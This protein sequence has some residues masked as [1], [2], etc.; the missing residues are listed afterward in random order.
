[1]KNIGFDYQKE[2]LEQDGTEHQLGGIGR[3]IKGIADEIGGIVTG[4]HAWSN[5]VD[6]I[7]QRILAQPNHAIDI[8]KEESKPYLPIGTIQRGREDW[9]NCTSNSCNNEIEIQHNYAIEKG[10]F[11]K[12][13]IQWF[14]ENK[15]IINGKFEI[16]DGFVSIGSGTTKT[17]NSLK[18]PLSFIENTGLIPKAMMPD[19]QSMTFEEYHRLNRVTQEMNDMAKEY[20]KRVK[21]NY[22]KVPST[23]F[24]TLIVK[25]LWEIFDSYVDHVDGDFIKQLAPDYMFIS[26]GYLIHI[27]EHTQNQFNFYQWLKQ[28]LC[29]R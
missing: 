18:A 21:I 4:L 1:M 15:Y 20:N 5:V 8:I 6:G 23:N 29:R 7:Y 25:I 13:L 22:K 27:N 17:G 11:S 24:A 19:N 2:L 16:A 3:N 14:E 26:H 28:Y 10:L 9:M 12:G